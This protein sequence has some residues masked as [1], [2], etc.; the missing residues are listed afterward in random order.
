[1]MKRFGLVRR[2]QNVCRLWILIDS[3]L[4]SYYTIHIYCISG[5][6]EAAENLRNKNRLIKEEIERTDKEIKE[7]EPQIKILEAV[8]KT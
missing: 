5:Y 7:I 8:Y 4:I 6:K 3:Q 1:M 2:H